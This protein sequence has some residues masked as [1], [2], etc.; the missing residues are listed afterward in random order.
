VRIPASASFRARVAP[1]P[2]SR[3]TGSRGESRAAG[4]GAGAALPGFP[5]GSG[6]S[7]YAPEDWNVRATSP[8]FSVSPFWRA[9]GVPVATRFSFTKVPFMTPI[10][11]IT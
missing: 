2:G 1:V 8:N 3:E 6:R 7:V 11:S 9:T 5:R 4:G 10:S